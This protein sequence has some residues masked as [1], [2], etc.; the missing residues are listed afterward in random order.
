MTSICRIPLQPNH[1]PPKLDCIIQ[2]GYMIV[3]VPLNTPIF[4]TTDL[5]QYPCC[6]MH[7]AS[8]MRSQNRLQYCDD[9]AQYA[10]RMQKMNYK[11]QSEK[12]ESGLCARRDCNNT[13][14]P[15]KKK[16]GV[17]GRCCIEHAKQCNTRA[18]LSYQRRKQKV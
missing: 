12:I 10:R 17:L 1:A 8:S 6:R 7:V 15:N 4:D 3:Q 9:H 11:R 14:A 5:C 18:K 2:D 16:P 13:R